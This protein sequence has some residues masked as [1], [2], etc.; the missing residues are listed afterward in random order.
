MVKIVML[1]AGGLAREM[2]DIYNEQ[3]RLDDFEFLVED[4]S[5]ERKIVNEKRVFDTNILNEISETERPEYRLICPIGTPRRKKLIERCI[6]LHYQ[7]DDLHHPNASIS[8]WSNIGTGVIISA[9]N[10]IKSQAEIGDYAILNMSCIVSHDAKV[11]KYST[12]SPFSGLMGFAEVGDECFLGAGVN[13]IP[14]VKVGKRCYI[15]AGSTVTKDI[16]DDTMAFGS[17]CKPIRTLSPED[18]KELF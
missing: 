3:G 17:P 7:F 16:P 14:G 5:R 10:I 9:N 11:G 15:G 4:N 18:W 12:I 8:K 2:M 1:G 13:I 6:D